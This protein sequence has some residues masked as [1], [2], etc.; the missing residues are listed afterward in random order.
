MP[1][2]KQRSSYLSK[3]RKDLEKL[4]NGKNATINDYDVVK[5]ESWKFYCLYSL[6]IKFFFAKNKH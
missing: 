3:I 5:R 6:I 1:N 4:S 2:K